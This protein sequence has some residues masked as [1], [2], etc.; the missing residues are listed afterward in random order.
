MVLAI[1]VSHSSPEDGNR[2][3]FRNAILLCFLENTGRWT[4]SKNPVIPNI[5]KVFRMI[6]VT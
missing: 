4:K 3:T 5:L 1:G 6:F 2:S